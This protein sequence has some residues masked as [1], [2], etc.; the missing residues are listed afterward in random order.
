VLGRSSALRK[1]ASS[2][3]TLKAEFLP[4]ESSL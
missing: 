2:D 3:E 1:S 4:T